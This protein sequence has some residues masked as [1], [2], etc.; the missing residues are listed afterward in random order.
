VEKEILFVKN[1][2]EGLVIM[3]K[4][5]VG[6]LVIV[7][8][9]LSAQVGVAAEKF[10]LP[11]DIREL[12]P[13]DAAA[14]VAIASMEEAEA[15]MTAVEDQLE[16]GEHSATLS[17]VLSREMPQLMEYLNTTQPFAVGVGLPNMMTM[18]PG[19]TYIL[20]LKDGAVV[21]DS[22]SEKWGFA[23]H[24]TSGNYIAFSSSL[25]YE[26]PTTINPLSD[27]LAAGVAAMSLDVQSVFEEFGGFLEMG[28]ASIPVRPEGT[29]PDGSGAMSL[30][31]AAALQEL[32]RSSLAA[33]TRLDLGVNQEGEDVSAYM[34]IGVVPGSGLDAGPQPDIEKAIALTSMLPSETDFVEVTAFDYTRIMA[35]FR[36]YYVMASTQ[37]MVGMDSE[38][39]AKY[40]AWVEEYLDGMDLWT[41]PLALSMRLADSQ[42][43]AHGVM[44]VPDGRAAVEQLTANFAGLTE[45]GLG[46]SLD[47]V[48][49]EKVGGVDFSVWEVNLDLDKI[50]SMVA[51]TR[52]P[53]S[54]GAGRMEA[55][56]LSSI[57]RKVMSKIY[58]GTD[59]GL[60]FMAADDGTEALAEMVEKSGKKGKPNADIVSLAKENGAH[61]QQIITGNMVAVINWFTEWMEE[62]DQKER[63]VL[64]GHPVPFSE[65][66][67]VS[68]GEAG[69]TF[70]TNLVA[71]GNLARAFE[72]MEAMHGGDDHPAGDHPEGDHPEGDHPE[73]PDDGE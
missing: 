1:T 20:P 36:D 8:C 62:I 65:V 18:S 39:R 38:A 40:R 33:I 21:P 57:L 30:E 32:I 71:L 28:M 12:I 66:A 59:D 29:E 44:E 56:Q 37:Q 25:D 3:R 70:K 14:V 69:V 11:D 35:T 42:M 13:S 53:A 63:D 61:T 73:H 46:Y 64:K 22:L 67:T 45:Q 17:E 47:P 27:H 43:A 7:F 34:G 48:A 15:L 54:G 23:S 16:G 72:E 55:E 26:K 52:S 9:V 6:T 10:A 68:E 19:L 5:L 60:L 50:E 41:N 24:A 4:S 31:E 2:L 49:N 51:D 58:V